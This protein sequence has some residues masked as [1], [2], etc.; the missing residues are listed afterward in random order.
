MKIFF[1]MDRNPNNVSGVSW[2]IWKIERKE[3]LLIDD[4]SKFV[5]I[6]ARKA[7]IDDGEEM[8]YMVAVEPV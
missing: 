1:Y 7:P 5:S 3:P 4:D 2:K 6:N 8:Y